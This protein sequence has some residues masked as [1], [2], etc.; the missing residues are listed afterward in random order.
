MKSTFQASYEVEVAVKLFTKSFDS[1][2]TIIFLHDWGGS[3]RTFSKVI[4]H[5]K[6]YQCRSVDLRGWGQ[7]S[8][9][10]IVDSG[11]AQPYSMRHMANDVVELIG[12]LPNIDDYMLVGHGMGAKVAQVIAGTQ[13]VGL[14]GL[15]LVAPAPASPLILG[16]NTLAAFKQALQNKDN[17]N[18]FILDCLAAEAQALPD[19]VLQQV[20]D[21]IMR[22]TPN[23]R[24]AWLAYGMAEDCSAVTASIS[25]PVCIVA[26]GRDRFLPFGMLRRQV[27]KSYPDARE[28]TMKQSGHLLPMEEPKVLAHLIETF[29]RDCVRL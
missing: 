15:V 23:A 4:E 25:V 5:I 21:D 24:S 26:G 18:R 29:V 10:P 17:T 9:A 11:D 14:L 12:M 27:M 1:G 19:L 8:V 2:T 6:A 3:T 22:G 28:Y 7:S 16:Q 20:A 13:P